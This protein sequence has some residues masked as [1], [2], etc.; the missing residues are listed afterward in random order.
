MSTQGEG[1]VAGL[2]RVPRPLNRIALDF[3][4]FSLDCSSLPRFVHALSELIAGTMTYVS[5]A[6][7]TSTF[8]ACTAGGQMQTNDGGSIAEP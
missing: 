6:N 3:K 4:Q 5:S 1:V 8:P 7:S 2:L